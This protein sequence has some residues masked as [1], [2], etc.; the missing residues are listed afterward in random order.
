MKTLFTFT[1]DPATLHHN[2]DMSEI[3]SEKPKPADYLHFT[4][5]SPEEFKG[6]RVLMFHASEH[7]LL[8]S[9]SVEALRK[10]NDQ[11]DMIFCC[12]PKEVARIFREVVGKK[13]Q[14]RWS[15]PTIFTLSIKE[16]LAIITFGTE[17]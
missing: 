12:F 4:V 2:F 3:M 16:T 14:G 13:V 9:G 17:K 1:A 7:G 11:T 8:P 15:T 5:S 10:Y 6:K